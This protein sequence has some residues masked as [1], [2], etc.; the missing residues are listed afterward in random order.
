M[1]TRIFVKQLECKVEDSC[2]SS[3]STSEVR[4]SAQVLPVM[5]QAPQ[6]RIQPASEARR[7][8]HRGETNWVLTSKYPSTEVSRYDSHWS[9]CNTFATPFNEI[10]PHNMQDRKAH[11]IQL[12]KFSR[13]RYPPMHINKFPKHHSHASG[14]QGLA[15]TRSKRPPRIA[16][17]PP[18]KKVSSCRCRLFVSL[19]STLHNSSY[20]CHS[21]NISTPTNSP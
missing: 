2:D 5:N 20:V 12:L 7:C 15:Q 8:R 17:Y 1:R 18:H 10:K 14:I 3:H 13:G 21:L 11:H 19:C 16:S 4:L 9:W 6:K